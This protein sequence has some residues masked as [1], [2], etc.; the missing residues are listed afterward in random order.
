[1]LVAP[2]YPQALDSAACRSCLRHVDVQCEG[3]HAQAYTHLA[4]ALQDA[5]LP[6]LRTLSIDPP[7][8]WAILPAL[9]DGKC[10]KLLSLRVRLSTTNAFLD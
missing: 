5:D 3:L 10:A 2:P 9:R 4:Q 7:G 6:S 1:M 8:L